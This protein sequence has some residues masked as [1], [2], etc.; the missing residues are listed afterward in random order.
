M[1]QKRTIILVILLAITATLMGG[2]WLAASRIQSPADAAAR[3][4][5]P[6]P[7]QILVPVERRVLSSTVVTRG[8][9]RFGLPLP[10]SIAP[11]LLKGDAALITTL[12]RRND[13]LE[14]G[15][16][17]L[18]ASGRP[19]V[20]L[21][22]NIPAYRDL[23]PGIVG[24]DVRQLEEALVR[25]GFDPGRV[26]RVYDART[27]AAVAAMY[28]AS[29]WEPFGPTVEQ[30]ARIHTLEADLGEAEKHL[31]AAEAAVA[32][33][34]L[35]VESERSRAELENLAAAAELESRLADQERLGTPDD[36]EPLALAS[37]RARA[38]YDLQTA[39]NELAAAK[40]DHALVVN[41]PRQTA[42]ARHAAEARLGLART[43]LAKTK[44]ECQIAVQAAE[45]EI[46]SAAERVAMARASV[47]ATRLAGETAVRSAIDRQS[48]ARFDVRLARTR[49]ERLQEEV[50]GVR[51]RLGV[52]I[53]VDEI[54]FVPSLPVRVQE[55][56]AV[57]GDPARGPVMSVTDNQLVVDS[58][59]P[60][61][62][63]PLVKA[64]MQVS[65]DEQALGIRAKGTVLR[66]ATTPGTFG[67]DGYHMHFEVAVTESATPLEGFSV[68]LTIPIE[69][70][71][72]DVIAVPTSALSLAADGRS[73]VQVSDG[74]GGTREVVVEPGLSAD[75]F[76]EVAPLEGTLEPGQLVVVGYERR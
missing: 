64:G 34:D 10:L 11:S 5:P 1:T 42:E 66:V 32:S 43:V 63:A 60:L 65:I 18:T 73:H 19:V 71:D 47:K 3:T 14:E 68:R 31:I 20:I 37:A 4:A 51:S 35:E 46:R 53:P 49:V 70:T 12:P 2:T 39:E 59:L 56:D 57:V 44:L 9:A 17:V 74:M 8:T 33:T 67:V 54:V 27:S 25:L 28:R 36:E 52:Q 30:L 38:A 55:I 48:V 7:S 76:V 40:A 26:D 50:D 61:Q 41:D 45:R 22:G 23:S 15:Q 6:E 62:V 75:G 21:Q 29:G 16:V 58:A 13:S 72:G 69:S 24:D